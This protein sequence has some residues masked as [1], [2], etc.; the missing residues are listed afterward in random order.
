[1]S[2]YYTVNEPNIFVNFLFA[3]YE[4]NNEVARCRLLTGL[5]VLLNINNGVPR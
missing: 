4:K 2:A 3:D 5:A 1:M